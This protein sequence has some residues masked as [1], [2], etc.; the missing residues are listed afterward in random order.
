M[1]NPQDW[2]YH[3]PAAQGQQALAGNNLDPP[4]YGQH[5]QAQ[6][7]AA[8]A[9]AYDMMK[10]YVELYKKVKVNPLGE[11]KGVHSAS[12]LSDE[13]LDLRGQIEELT[14]S[15]GQ[16]SEELARVLESLPTLVEVVRDIGTVVQRRISS[17]QMV[18]TRIEKMRLSLPLSDQ[19]KTE[20]KQA[21]DR[22]AQA[23]A[24]QTAGAGLK[25]IVPGLWQQGP[26]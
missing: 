17:L 22:S 19:L 5:N 2:F 3:I 25:P 16:E 10:E 21:E 14:K 9:E 13:Y 4:N 11:V 8:P 1:P 15:I 26:G 7:G 6:V 23:Q 24:D 20:I 18:A 12:Q